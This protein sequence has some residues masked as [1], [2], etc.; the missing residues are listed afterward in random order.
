MP[1]SHNKH[2]LEDVL[3]ILGLKLLWFTACSLSDIVC[4]CVCVCVCVFVCLECVCVCL[5]VLLSCVLLLFIHREL[6]VVFDRF[7]LK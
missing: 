6:F 2:A 4:V 5:S 3:R 7:C 1:F